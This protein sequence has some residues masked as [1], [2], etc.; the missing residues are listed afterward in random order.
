MALKPKRYVRHLPDQMKRAIVLMYYGNA[1]NFEAR[2]FSLEKV[3]RLL[4]IPKSTIHKVIKAFHGQGSE[5]LTFSD[6][7]K[8]RMNTIKALTQEESR[9]EAFGVVGCSRNIGLK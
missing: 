8:K 9:F 4:T 1:T 2:Q 3:G 5:I 6:G 7:R